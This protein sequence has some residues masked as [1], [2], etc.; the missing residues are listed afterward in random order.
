MAVAANIEPIITL[1]WDINSPTD[2]VRRLG[3]EV[4][5]NEEGEGEGS[6]FFYGAIMRN[7]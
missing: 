1:A 3:E 6:R 2:W 5:G 7:G 4:G